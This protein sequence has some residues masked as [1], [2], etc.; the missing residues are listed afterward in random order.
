[1][2]SPSATL[3]LRMLK[4]DL[5]HLH[6]YAHHGLFKE[7]KILGGEFEVNVTVWHVE[8]SMSLKYIDEVIDYTQVYDVIK[9]LM[10]KPT[11]LLE[12]LVIN[13]ARNILDSF[14]AA[15]EVKVS[16]TKLHPPIIAFN[17]EVSLSYHLKR[18]I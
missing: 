17:G 3:V 14:S 6:F 10:E 8:K 7:E 9:T 5:S 13:I 11:P 18:T 2:F 1:L 15:Q 4:L 12:T 16:I